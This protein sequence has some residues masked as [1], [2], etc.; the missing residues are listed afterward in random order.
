MVIAHNGTCTMY[1]NLLSDIK[2]AKEAGYGGIE[3][4]GSK[5]YR[6]LDQGFTIDDVNKAL[7]GFPVVGIGFIADIERCEGKDYNDLIGETEKMCSA[8]QK[9]GCDSVQLLTGP[10]DD[11]A[12]SDEYKKTLSLPY[13]ELKGAVVN[14]LKAIAD[15]GENYNVRFYLEPLN[16]CR[17]CSLPQMLELINEAQRD[18]IGIVIDFWHM[19]NTGTTAEDLAKL[20]KNM[21]YGVHFCDS[22]EKHN[23]RGTLESVGRRVWTGEGNIPV[24]E[25]LDAIVSTGFDGWVS[26]ELFSPKHW[27]LDPLEVAEKLRVLLEEML[28]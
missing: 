24:K 22:L 3:I 7:D 21:I 1:C 9:L 19:W 27:E 28:V 18:N 12:A 13:P 11:K 15:I 16:W 10:L 2:I 23:E 6:F 20:D 8:A 25:W 14:N 4:V 17:I 26:G 5:L